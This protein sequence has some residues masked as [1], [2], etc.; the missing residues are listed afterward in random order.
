MPGNILLAGFPLSN[1]S[2]GISIA[3]IH[4]V[5]DKRRVERRPLDREKQVGR[6]VRG[7]AGGR[8]R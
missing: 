5:T 6:K 3:E 2:S 1:A 8:Q 7:S 4:P